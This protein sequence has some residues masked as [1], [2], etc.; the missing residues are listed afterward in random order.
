MLAGKLR[1]Y[2]TILQ[3]SI[4]RNSFNEEI[5]TWVN[6]ASVWAN[7]VAMGGYEKLV[8]SADQIVS[9]ASH[10]IQI[11]YRSDIAASMR[12]T[13]E[14]RSFNILTFNDPNQKK[15]ML[16]LTCEEIL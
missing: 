1:S 12:I 15:Q 13:F 3:K 7:V 14:N 16:F 2:V 10:K 9:T 6:V 8:K 5:V 4:A 11:R